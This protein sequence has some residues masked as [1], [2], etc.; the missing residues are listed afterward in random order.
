MDADGYKHDAVA[1]R[2]RA[3]GSRKADM[4]GV[5]E[6]VVKDA[7]DCIHS[8]DL[9][10]LWSVIPQIALLDIPIRMQIRSA[11][12]KAFKADLLVADWDAEIGKYVEPTLPRRPIDPGSIRADDV[13]AGPF[14]D[15]ANA[16]RMIRLH[17]KDMQ[18][19]HGF[20]K[21]VTWDGRRWCVDDTGQAIRFAK[22]AMTAFLHQAI[23]AGNEPAEKFATKSLDARRINS[24]LSMA[25]SEPGCFVKAEELDSDP[26]LLNCL[27]GTV[28]LRTGQLRHHDRDDKITKLVHHLYE[29]SAECPTWRKFLEEIMGGGPDAGEPELERADRLLEYLQRAIGYSLTGNVNEKAVFVLFGS[30]N[31][32]KS[33][34]LAT[35]RELIREYSVLIDVNTLMVR[36]ET[37]NTQAD[38][39][40][41]R[42]ARFAQTS[43]VEEGQRLAQG[44]LKRITQGMGSIKACRKYENPIEF[45]ETHKLWMDTNRKPLIKDGD[46][47][48][49]FNRLHSIPFTVSIPSERIDRELPTK[50]LAEA[51]GILAWCVEGS[52]LWFEQGLQKPIEVQQANEEWKAESDQVG[53]FIEECCETGEG[54]ARSASEIYN[55][56][57]RW[58]ESS[59]EHPMTQKAFGSKLGSRGFEKKQTKTGIKY[60]GITIRGAVGEEQADRG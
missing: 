34:M 55:A 43:E 24:A 6:I 2:G 51:A 25:E 22:L 28:D 37:S 21:W 18:Y 4:D 53:M 30:G 5:A 9:A 35:I 8:A 20:R 16:Q 11:A 1:R 49:T 57:K 52:R 12:K 39:A 27:N 14:N 38:M 45:P 33:T 41:L 31:N 13:I 19:C 60:K 48:A 32:G 29:P 42:G 47:R 56:Y 3:K 26:F 50:L 46:D 36:Q 58:A 54:L 44:K 15:L 23:K 10:A 17:G 40:D 7:M 59:G